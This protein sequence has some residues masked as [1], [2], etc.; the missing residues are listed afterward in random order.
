MQ[1]DEVIKHC[2]PGG[3]KLKLLVLANFL[4]P[5]SV[6]EAG[7]EIFNLLEQYGQLKQVLSDTRSGIYK[8]PG[9]KSGSRERIAK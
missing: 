5:A 2:P 3:G 4:E 6:V 7:T 8:T 9:C 1:G